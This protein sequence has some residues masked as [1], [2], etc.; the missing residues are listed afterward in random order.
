MLIPKIDFQYWFNLNQLTA[1]TENRFV[2]MI[3]R[4]NN[5]YKNDSNHKQ[6]YFCGDENEINRL[7]SL[8]YL[9]LEDEILNKI[10]AHPD[11]NNI[12]DNVEIEKLFGLEIL[13]IFDLINVWGGIQGG[14]NFY[15]I[16]KNTS[17][18]IK[19]NIWLPKYIK[20]IKKAILKDAS[21]YD[22]V[23]NGDIPNLKMSFGSKHISF[24]SRK[25]GNAKCLI[26]IDNKIA[27]ATGVKIAKEAEFKNIIK[28]I[29]ELE[30]EL[31]IE[32]QKV[33]KAVFTFHEYYFDNA[34]SKFNNNQEGLDY[35]KAL[36]I[37]NKLNIDDKINYSNTIKITKAA[38]NRKGNF[39]IFKGEIKKSSDGL[40]FVIN[41]AIERCKIPS[42]KID[43]LKY[44]KSGNIIFYKFNGGIDSFKII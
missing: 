20:I 10:I 25:N 32:P 1:L 35:I 14:S 12:D 33:E 42:N 5:I 24:W 36:I 26:I 7:K 18:R 38:I 3:T 21:S 8:N 27:G 11:I 23:L 40:I 19:Y 2:S 39:E 44:L 28:E 17:T 30:D 15:N 34:N 9:Q 37:K 4:I 29:H 16:K 13:Q 6:A 31:K 43:K 22:D 41:S